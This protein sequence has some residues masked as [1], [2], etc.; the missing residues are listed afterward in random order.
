MG[1]SNELAKP[2]TDEEFEVLG[3]YAYVAVIG[4]TAVFIRH[5]QEN[6]IREL[7]QIVA[8]AHPVIAQ[9]GAETP[10]LGDNRCGY[11]HKVNTLII[12]LTKG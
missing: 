8:V 6:Q 9:R 4:R 3:G 7:L 2:E 10:D 5:F 12:T 11:V 1:V